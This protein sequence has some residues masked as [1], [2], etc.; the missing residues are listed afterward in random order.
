M[1][2]PSTRAAGHD[3]VMDRVGARRR[4]R[5]DT[6]DFL[7]PLGLYVLNGWVWFVFNRGGDEVGPTLAQAAVMTATTT[8][9]LWFFAHRGHR[10]PRWVLVVV[11]V[12]SAAG[13]VATLNWWSLL[14]ICDL[15]AVA[16]LAWGWP[17]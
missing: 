8:A 14:A 5:R 11:L 15:S 17:R 2:F 12:M 13:S 9:L 16:I 10:W 6:A 3:A 1:P 4:V 7:V